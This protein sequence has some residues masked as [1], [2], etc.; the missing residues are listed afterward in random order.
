MLYLQAANPQMIQ[1][2]LFGGIFIVFYFFM[3]RPQQKKAKEAKKFIEELKAGDKIVTIGG[4][5]GTIVTIREKTFLVEVDSSKG[6]RIVFEKSAISKD[7]SSR[8]TEE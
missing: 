6:V 7:G 2:L 8:L 1:I 4:A 5:H 3:I